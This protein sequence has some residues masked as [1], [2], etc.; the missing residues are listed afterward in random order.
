MRWRLAD[1][2]KRPDIV[3]SSNIVSAG[4]PRFIV[5]CKGKILFW[6]VG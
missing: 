3:Y 4:S 2:P 6:F 5:A 1:R